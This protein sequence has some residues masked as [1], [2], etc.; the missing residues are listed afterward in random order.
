MRKMKEIIVEI[1]CGS[2]YDGLQAEAGGAKRIELNCAL[3]L[4][5]LTPS[6]AELILLK[7]NTSLNIV[8]MVRPRGAGFCY[9]AQDFAVMYADCELLLKHGADGIAFGCLEE[10]GT[11]H[12]DQTKKLL[13]LIKSYQKEAVFHRAF[14]CVPDA[15]AAIQLLISLG[16]DRILTSGLKEKAFDGAGLIADLQKQYGAQIEILAG[17]GVNSGNAAELLRLTGINQIHSSC[18]AWLPDPTTTGKHVTYAY[19]AAADQDDRNR[20]EIVSADLV[21]ELIDSVRTRYQLHHPADTKA[22]A[23]S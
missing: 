6:L 4:G 8:T 5:G 17:S 2:Y 16:V 20:Y 7:Q 22:A 12:I 14:D 15:N 13:S 23:P 9:H 18:K 3:H 10:D 11:I 1:C 19:A 21:K